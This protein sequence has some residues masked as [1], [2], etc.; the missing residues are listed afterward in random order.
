M[1]NMTMDARHG[2]QFL[3]GFAGWGIGGLADARSPKKT[4]KT[5]QVFGTSS[6]PVCPVPGELVQL[7]DVGGGRAQRGEC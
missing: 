2:L 7:D 6:T 5:R 1:V 3:S 4:K